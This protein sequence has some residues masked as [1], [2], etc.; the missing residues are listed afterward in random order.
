MEKTF[1]TKLSK[2]AAESVETKAVIDWTDV[3][4]KELQEL[5]AATVVINQQSIYRTSGTIPTT[6]T[7]S[8]RKQLDSPRGGGFK[9]TPE[10]MAAKI[11]KMGK[12]EYAKSLTLLGL[13]E[14]EVQKMVSKKFPEQK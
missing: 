14:K 6:D 1:K 8:V 5:A 7:I 11:G 9:V 2:D 4:E 13:N 3:T 10:S 12:E